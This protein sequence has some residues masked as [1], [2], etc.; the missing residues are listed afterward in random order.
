MRSENDIEFEKL[1]KIHAAKECQECG[2]RFQHSACCERSASGECDKAIRHRVESA[3]EARMDLFRKN[4][5]LP[6]R[7][8]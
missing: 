5:G 1:W 7:N 4:E 3:R 6:M 2:N 8:Q